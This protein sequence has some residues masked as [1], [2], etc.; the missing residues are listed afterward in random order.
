[1]SLGANPLIGGAF[2]D[3]GFVLDDVLLA[4]FVLT[5]PE[6]CLAEPG[7]FSRRSAMLPLR[8]MDERFSAGISIP[9]IVE[10]MRAV[11]LAADSQKRRK[12]RT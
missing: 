12:M 7:F 6:N 4:I 1:M 11:E 9:S 8:G 5:M 3:E 2:R 10:N